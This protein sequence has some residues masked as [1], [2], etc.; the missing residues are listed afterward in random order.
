[1]QMEEKVTAMQ[2]SDGAIEIVYFYGRRI[3]QMEQKH[4]H[5]ADHAVITCTVLKKRRQHIRGII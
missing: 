2:L 3:M 1:M 4:N 5:A